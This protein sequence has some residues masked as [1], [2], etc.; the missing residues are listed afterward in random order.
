M[1][2]RLEVKNRARVHPIVQKKVNVPLL[3]GL[4]KGIGCF[5]AR[6]PQCPT[7]LALL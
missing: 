1:N 2:L 3:S 5:P 7:I 6:E 4:Q